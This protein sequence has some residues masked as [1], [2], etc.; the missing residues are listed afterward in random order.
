MPKFARL[1][2]LTKVSFEVSSYFRI[3]FAVR[4]STVASKYQTL[5]IK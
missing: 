3:Y 2:S 4:Q 5:R 1:E